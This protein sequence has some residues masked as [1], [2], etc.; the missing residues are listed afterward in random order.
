MNLLRNESANDRLVALE[1]QMKI[2][3][4]SKSCVETRPQS[5]NEKMSDNPITET[6]ILTRKTVKEPDNKLYY[7][8]R[9]GKNLLQ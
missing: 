3:T 1:R 5:S 7:P 4:S 9:T 8:T 2:L 6:M